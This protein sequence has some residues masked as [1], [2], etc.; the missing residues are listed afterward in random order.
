M[1]NVNYT[2]PHNV[3]LEIGTA[4]VEVDYANYSTWF[5]SSDVNCPVTLFELLDINKTAL[6]SSV[7]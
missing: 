1:T 4:A 5:V 6:V 2:Y 3:S 7:V